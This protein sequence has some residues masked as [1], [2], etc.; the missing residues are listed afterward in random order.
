MLSRLRDNASLAALVV[1]VMALF[2]AI[3]G[4]AGALPGKKSVDKND[5]KKNVVASKN[6]G[7]D[8]LTGGDIKE[9]TLELPASVTKTFGVSS[10]ATGTVTAS[11]LPGTTV[12]N[13]AGGAYSVT[14]PKSVQG[15]APV[16]SDDG[17]PIV[18]LR[19]TLVSSNPNQVFVLFADSNNSSFNLIVTCP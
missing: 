9:S 7:E 5:L 15:C 6:V 1:A 13:T 17:I 12:A 14:F 4:I 2:V 18:V 19:T 16:A 8:A 3:S 10:N 11:T